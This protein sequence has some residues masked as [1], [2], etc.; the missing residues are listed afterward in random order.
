MEWSVI[1]SDSLSHKI[2]FFHGLITGSRTLFVD[3]NLILDEKLKFK[4]VGEIPPFKIGTHNLR[5]KI[6]APGANSDDWKYDLFV[7]DKPVKTHQ[8]HVT[9]QLIRFQIQIKGQN[10][11]VCLHGQQLQV[12]VD[13]NIVETE[14]Q[15]AEEGEAEQT[16]RVADQICTLSTGLESVESESAAAGS[17]LKQVFSYKLTV[18]DD[19]YAPLNDASP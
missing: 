3:G 10:H 6:T 5:L 11:M 4:L 19:V 18:G 2:V 1:L 8:A 16:F 13:G 12:Y 15:F 17:A 14:A 7:D 9:K